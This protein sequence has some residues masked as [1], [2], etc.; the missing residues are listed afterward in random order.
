MK[1]ASQFLGMPFVILFNF[2]FTSI[3]SFAI[4]FSEFYSLPSCS[5][6]KNSNWRYVLDPNSAVFFFFW[7]IAIAI[8]CGVPDIGNHANISFDNITYQSSVEYGCE[9]GYV[10][11]AG[12]R[13][14]TCSATGTWTGEP[15]ECS[16]NCETFR[17]ETQYWRDIG[18]EKGREREGERERE[19]ERKRER[20][21]ERERDRERE[22]FVSQLDTSSG[23]PFAVF[24]CTFACTA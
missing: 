3:H 17:N 16:G 23:H 8:H 14:R 9:E 1:L 7:F 18:L 2:V 13:K 10:Q 19:R 12:N 6:L 22:R 21:R 4:F 11:V 20:E 24:R 15:L 5:K